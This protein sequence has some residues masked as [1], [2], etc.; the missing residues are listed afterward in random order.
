MSANCKALL[1]NIKTLLLLLLKDLTQASAKGSLIDIQRSPEISTNSN[2]EEIFIAE[3]NSLEEIEE[4]PEIS[5]FS[6]E[7]IQLIEEEENKAA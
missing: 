6:Q 7:V 3:P 1:K 4:D 5:K 2:H